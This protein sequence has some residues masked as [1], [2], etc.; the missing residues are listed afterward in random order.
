[1]GSEDHLFEQRTFL[2]YGIAHHHDVGSGLKLGA[3]HLRSVDAATDD[4]WNVHV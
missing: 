3:G 4:E 1:M 2:F